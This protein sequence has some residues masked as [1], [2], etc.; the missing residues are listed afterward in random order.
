MVEEILKPASDLITMRYCYTDTD[1]YENYKQLFGK[2]VPFTTDK[3]VFT[4]DGYISVG[5]NL[6]DINYYINDSNKTINIIL[7]DIVVIANEIDHSSFEYPY[8]SDSIFNSTDMEDF[9]QLINS[10]KEKKAGDVMN[11]K[12][13]MDSAEENTKRV[14][15]GFLTGSESTK[16]YTVKFQ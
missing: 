16:D 4:Y 14:I 11:N 7:P 5:M 6:S 13:F 9:T 1:T 10:L 8:Q 3:V 12:R 15:E 2:K